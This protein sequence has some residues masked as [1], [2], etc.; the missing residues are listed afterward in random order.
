MLLELITAILV[1]LILL[2]LIAVYLAWCQ[3]Q[4]SLSSPDNT[5]LVPKTISDS[6]GPI[7]FM[8]IYSGLKNFGTDLSTTLP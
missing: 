1:I 2:Y 5:W 8:I 4:Y 3:K 6:Y 7:R